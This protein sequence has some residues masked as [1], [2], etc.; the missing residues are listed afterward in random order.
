MTTI[1]NEL[2]E[3]EEKAWKSLASYKMAMFGYWAGIWVHLNRLL[4]SPR[5]NPFRGI[6]KI[7]KK[8]VARG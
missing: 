2:A 6:V 3:A 5:P 4:P 8:E 1:A 7:A